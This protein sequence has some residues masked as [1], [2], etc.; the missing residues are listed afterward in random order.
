MEQGSVVTYPDLPSVLKDK[1]EDGELRAHFH[2]PIFLEKFEA[3]H[4]TQDHIVKVLNV[5][6]SEMVSEHLEV[7]TYTWDVLPEGL[8]QELSESIVRELQWVQE[9]L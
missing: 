3:L 2:V 8:K 4:S 1:N 5:L 9:R 7:E 6:K